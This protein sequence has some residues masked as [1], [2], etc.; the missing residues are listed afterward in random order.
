MH[1][2]ESVS[3]A[4][5]AA[6][7]AEN[8][9]AAS[10]GHFYRVSDYYDVGREKV[11]EYARAVQD[12]HPVH[13]DEGVAAEYG[14]A[15]LL[16]PLTF[17]SLVGILAQ[18]KMN[19]QILAGYEMIVQADQVLEFHRPILVGDRLVCD[20]S[21]DSF[22]S[23]P[24]ADLLVTKNVVSSSDELVMVTY[25]TIA[26]QRGGANA[27][28]LDA[29]RDV[30]MHGLSGDDPTRL[31]PPHRPLGGMSTAAPVPGPPRPRSTRTRSFD[32]VAVGDRLPPR[33]VGLSRGDLVN[34]AG[35]SG[36]AN[37][38]HFS[39]EVAQQAGLDTVIA[40]GMLTMGLG[41]GYLTSWLGDPG[42]VL[43][44]NV[45]FSSMVYVP[46]SAGAEIEFSGR[47]KSVDE[48][49]RTAVL[50]LTGTCAGKRIFGRATATVQ[51]G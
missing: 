35:V 39:P 2:E 25:T 36:D 12:Y 19:A 49:A 3:S 44:Y 32:S 4:P 24:G 1:I 23:A 26:A 18:S 6:E 13:W 48:A 11:R 7:P 27:S 9:A 17:I 30:S 45:R 40:H 8:S 21:L 15:G 43:D 31:P 16:A 34:Y 41:A 38:I 10:V 28:L 51:L 20:V 37:P 50:A 22:R 42:S 5:L 47:I 33:T 46:E 14:Y 29:V